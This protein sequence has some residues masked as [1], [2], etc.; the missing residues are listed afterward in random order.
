MFYEKSARKCQD[1]KPDP[2]IYWTSEQKEGRS[3]HDLLNSSNAVFRER[4]Y[5]KSSDTL[6]IA[7]YRN[8]HLE[9]YIIGKITGA[10]IIV[11]SKGKEKILI[12]PKEPPVWW[13]NK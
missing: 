2:I 10:N 13:S 3:W 11:F 1:V 9:N 8:D 6:K 12:R 4:S 5:D 7:E